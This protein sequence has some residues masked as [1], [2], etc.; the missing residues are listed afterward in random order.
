M[1][2]LELEV[3][4]VALNDESIPWNMRKVDMKE[5]FD[6]TRNGPWLE[7]VNMRRTLLPLHF[8]APGANLASRIINSDRWLNSLI[9]S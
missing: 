3:Y 5:M 2:S 6:R 1:N 8:E 7:R 9:G 4:K